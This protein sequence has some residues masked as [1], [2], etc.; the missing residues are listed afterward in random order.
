MRVHG[1]LVR[2]SCAVGP[3]QLGYERVA[4]AG[5]VAADGLL[6]NSRR[7]DV[8]A[9]EGRACGQTGDS[10]GDQRKRGAAGAERRDVLELDRERR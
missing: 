8:F 4:E 3:Q 9:W 6:R 5:P 2:E 10:V 7:R 1:G